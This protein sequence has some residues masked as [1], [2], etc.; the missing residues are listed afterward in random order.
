MATRKLVK[1]SKKLTEEDIARVEKKLGL[2]LPEDLKSLYLHYNGGEVEGGRKIFLTQEGMEYE[3]KS[4]L[5]MLYPRFEADALL[6][7]SYVFFVKEKK[8][9]P[10]K[11]IPFAMDSGGFRYCL[12]VSDGKVYF[13]NWDKDCKPQDYMDLVASSAGG[14][15]QGMVTEKEAFR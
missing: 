2:S 15:I 14:F 9:I 4:F 10:K 5:Q 3:V 1:S 11:Y 12:N 6:E 13:S 7:D 8:L